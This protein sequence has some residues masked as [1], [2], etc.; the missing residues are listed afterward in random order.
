MVLNVVE[1]AII[2]QSIEQG[3]NL[4]L[5][6][7]DMRS[8]TSDAVRIRRQVSKHNPVIHQPVRSAG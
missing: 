2:R 6:S 5:G 1:T 4:V 7:H 8:V 3:T